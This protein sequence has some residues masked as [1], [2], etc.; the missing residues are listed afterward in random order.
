MRPLIFLLVHSFRSNRWA[1]NMTEWLKL[2][3]SVIEIKNL[4]FIIFSVI[5]NSNYW[6]KISTVNVCLYFNACI[7]INLKSESH[8][9]FCID[10]TIL[11]RQ[12]L[13][14]VIL[15]L[16]HKR[17]TPSLVFISLILVQNEKKKKVSDLVRLFALFS[18]LLNKH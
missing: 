17:S 1:S 2:I 12:M 14:F 15:F 16:F 3:A 11:R 9:Y 13:C 8:F 7:R 18:I 6:N 10:K 4:P 5:P